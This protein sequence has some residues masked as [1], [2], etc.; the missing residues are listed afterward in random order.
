MRY[1][2]TPTAI[3]LNYNG[4]TRI[5][6]STDNRFKTIIDAIKAKEFDKIPYIVD[7][8]K[9]AIA[10]STNEHFKVENGRVYIDNT[11]V[12][13]RISEKIMEY[14]NLGLDPASLVNFHRNL[15]KNPSSR[16]RERLFLFLENGNH[17]ITDDGYFIAYKKVKSDFTDSH[18][19]KIDNSVGAKPSMKREDV[20]DDPEHTCSRGLHVASWAY[21]QGYSGQ[22]L[23]DVKVNPK[24][25]VAIPTDYSNQKMRVSE[26]EVIAVSTGPKQEVHIS[27][28]KP[29]KDIDDEDIDENPDIDDEDPEFDLDASDLVN[30]SE[31]LDNNPEYQQG[32]EDAKA[33]YVYF[34]SIG[35]SYN[36]EQFLNLKRFETK[37][38][39]YQH[40]VEKAVN[41]LI[42]E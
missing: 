37:S 3:S 28:N 11:A 33:L 2:I 6:E 5:V 15:Q 13:S 32:Y 18:T 22:I 41:E 8:I 26:Y 38:I 21:A 19:G 39:D 4:N 29:L 16:A 24:D 40:G 17:P 7:A 30:D 12:C 10:T 20:D 23:I 36:R 31:D 1:L 25:V 27:D 34:S 42:D 9:N 14:I 35:K